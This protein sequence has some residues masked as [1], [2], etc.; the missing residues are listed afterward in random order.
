MVVFDVVRGGNVT[1]D[2][3][4]LNHGKIVLFKVQDYSHNT[5]RLAAYD[6]KLDGGAGP[7]NYLTLFQ[8]AGKVYPNDDMS[9]LKWTVRVTGHIANSETKPTYDAT[10]LIQIPDSAAKVGI[11]RRDLL[12]DVARLPL[13]NFAPAG[14]PWF[15]PK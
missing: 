13:T 5:S 8:Y 4:M 7:E 11:F 12:F 6:V 2:V 15:R 10:K 14:G 1:A 9:W 3:V